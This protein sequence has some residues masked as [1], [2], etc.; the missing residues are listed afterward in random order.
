[1]KKFIISIF[2]TILIFFNLF[3]KEALAC[4]IPPDI[5]NRFYIYEEN[6]KLKVEYSLYTWQ[7]IKE[8]LKKSF[9]EN[10]NKDLTEEN[11][12]VFIQKYI[13][14]ISSLSLN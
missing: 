10:T 13:K 7:K 14:E 5:L 11:I 3:T 8:K 4:S 9:K 6:N 12:D 2:L 1:M